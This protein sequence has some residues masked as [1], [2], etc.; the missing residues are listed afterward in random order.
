MK[1]VS[2]ICINVADG[3]GGWA[4]IGID[5]G[6]YA[7]RL[8]KN[9]ERHVI[10][11]VDTD[12]RNILHEAHKNMGKVIGSTTA[13]IATIDEQILKCANLGDSGFI[14]LRYGVSYDDEG[15]MSGNCCWRVEKISADQQ[16]YFN[17]PYQLGTDS[18]ELPKDAEVYEFPLETFDILILATDGLFDNLF[19]H[20]IVDCVSRHFPSLIALQRRSKQAIDSL[21]EELANEAKRV[22]ELNEAD[23]PFTRAA[24]ASNVD[25]FSGKEDDIT[26]IV[27]LVV[28]AT[29][30]NCQDSW[31]ENMS[32]R[33]SS[34]QIS[35]P[36]NT[37][38]ADSPSSA[39]TH[40][41]GS[42]W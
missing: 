30:E 10:S 1:N 41:P 38:V 39:S 17:C 15:D 19:A 4:S 33:L 26:L 2:W 42:S 23:T 20:Q 29:N 3:V 16:H 24:K 36:S 13:C 32:P 8:M 12:P 11:N 14:L 5:A 34:F 27:S 31:I 28:N 25:F 7:R 21:T 6:R 35:S 37:T 22:S 9:A 40:S 18:G